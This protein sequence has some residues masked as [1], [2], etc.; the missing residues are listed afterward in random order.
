[1]P[2]VGRRRA[3]LARGGGGGKGRELGSL[4]VVASESQK[5]YSNLPWV[6]FKVPCVTVAEVVATRRWELAPDGQVRSAS[7]A[8]QSA[9]VKID[10]EGVDL[11]LV[12]AYLDQGER[13]HVYWCVARPRLLTPPPRPPSPP[14]LPPRR[15]PRSPSGSAR[16]IARA[17]I[18][19]CACAL[20]AASGRGTRTMCSPRGAA[21]PSSTRAR[22]RSCVGSP[23]RAMSSSP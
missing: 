2:H 10:A 22:S 14:P 13:P 19:V 15:S 1:M 18:R 16:L 12:G 8:D 20:G 11:E 5:T 9:I 3:L 6:E 4:A 17:S 7:A 21:R 23:T